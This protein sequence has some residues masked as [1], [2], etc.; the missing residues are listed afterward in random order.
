MDVPVIVARP[1]LAVVPPG[2]PSHPPPKPLSGSVAVLP[3][4]A[5]VGHVQRGL[6]DDDAT[7]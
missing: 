7:G 1:D 5:P 4:I 6:V 2:Q 3:L